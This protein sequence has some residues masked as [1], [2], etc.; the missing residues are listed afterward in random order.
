MKQAEDLL[1]A[2][3]SLD[4]AKFQLTNGW[5]IIGFESEV[6]FVANKQATYLPKTA[7][8]DREIFELISELNAAIEPVLKRYSEKCKNK[9]K[10]QVN[11]L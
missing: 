5:G 1:T 3:K 6:K 4:S 9:L 7:F 10:E 8:D 2:I 11:S